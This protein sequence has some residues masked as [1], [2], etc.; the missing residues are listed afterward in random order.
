MTDPS[1]LKPGDLFNTIDK[2]ARDAA[3][4]MGVS[5]SFDKGWEYGTIIYKISKT[6][7][8]HVTKSKIVWS[9]SLNI[10]W[11]GWKPTRV[12]Y[13]NAVETKV[14]KYSYVEPRTDK[15]PWGV[16]YPSTPFRKERVATVHTHPMGSG[17]GITRFSN[18]DKTN[19]KTRGV[20]NYVYGPNGELRKYDPATGKDKL[21]YSDLPKSK[22]TPWKK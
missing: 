8:T 1:G 7:I 15:D 16:S 4:Y 14:T 6:G 9:F 2:A 5:R 17:L 11:P 22:K 12:Y 3:I 20:P 18:T 13:K 10:F 19:A 21:L